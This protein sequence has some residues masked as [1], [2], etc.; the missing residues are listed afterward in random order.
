[1][2]VLYICTM[3]PGV[4]WRWQL[5]WTSYLIRI[6]RAYLTDR[7]LRNIGREVTNTCH[8]CGEGEVT[9]QYTLE[10]YPAW[11]VPRHVLPLA[12]GESL[13][14]S[15][16]VEAMLRGQQEFLAVRS[17]CEEEM[18]AKERAE[19]ERVNTSHPCKVSCHPR[20]SSRREG[21]GFSLDLHDGPGD[22]VEG[23]GHNAQIKPKE[24]LPKNR[25]RRKSSLAAIWK[26]SRGT[27]F[28]R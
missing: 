7:Y 24:W 13:G 17:Y 6:I 3:F 21:S 8:H 4:G 11:Q 19:W 5:L 9:A 12:I 25:R 28:K 23:C 2:N 15:P 18:L 27:P 22:D 10:F 16:V 14:P 20:W 1:M 26:R